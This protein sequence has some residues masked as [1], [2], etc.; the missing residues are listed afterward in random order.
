MR[1]AVGAE[2]LLRV[3][4]RAI[5]LVDV[6]LCSHVVVVEEAVVDA[7]EAVVEA[8]EGLSVCCSEV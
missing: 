8:V 5:I 3:A 1:L 6:D 2:L 4:E 7:V